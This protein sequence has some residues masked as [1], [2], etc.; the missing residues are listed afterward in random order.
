[1][2]DGEFKGAHVVVGWGRE[3]AGAELDCATGGVKADQIAGGMM[4]G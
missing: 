1:M 4:F 3:A 2:E